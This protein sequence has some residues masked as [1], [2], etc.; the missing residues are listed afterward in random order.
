MRAIKV[1][2][3]SSLFLLLVV[4]ARQA[5]AQ[6]SR[7]EAPVTAAIATA[8]D[9]RWLGNT[10]LPGVVVDMDAGPVFLDYFVVHP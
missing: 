3:W 6:S 2:L 10:V 4:G 8:M 9:L 5:A 1:I 7:G